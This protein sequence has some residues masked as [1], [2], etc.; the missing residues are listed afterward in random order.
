MNLKIDFVYLPGLPEGTALLV[1]TED[2][3]AF[4]YLGVI[5]RAETCAIIRGIGVEDEP[6]DEI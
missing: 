1:P 6:D 4:I 2:L 5:P 3:G